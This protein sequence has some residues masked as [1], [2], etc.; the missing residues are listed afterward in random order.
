MSRRPHVAL[1]LSG[2]ELRDALFSPRLRTR[3]HQLATCDFDA[4]ITDFEEPPVDL[5]TVDVLLT[6]WG[7]PR[8]DSAALALLPRLELVAH[9]GG[10]VKGHVDRVCWDRGITVTTAATANA[11]PVAEFTV[12]QIILAGKATQAAQ[13]LYTKRQRKVGREDLP[14]IGNYDRT[15]GI[16]GASTIGRLVLARLQTFDLDVVVSDPTL[17]A[18]EAAQ[19]GTAL[20]SLDELM[21]LSDVVS[22]HAPLLPST[23]NMI[24]PDQ[25]ARMKNGAT[26][27]NTARGLLVDHTALRA[28][29]ASGRINAVLDVTEPEPL[30]PGDVL[31]GLPNVQLTPHIAGSMGTEL[32]R[33]TALALDEIE[34]LAQ[35]T[36]FRFAVMRQ[37]LDRMA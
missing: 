12:A 9:A 10:T 6:G 15:V 3:L 22:L 5:S 32:H 25:L 11:V 36:P 19:L 29:L 27:I 14:L 20:V 24:G 16:I 23:I 18:D 1:A 13:H 2:P 37:D 30:E 4:V 33:M 7:C 21:S 28:E 31:Y 35:D 34:H 8:I 26:F 17:T